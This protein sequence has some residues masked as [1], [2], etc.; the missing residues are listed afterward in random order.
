[1]AGV[2][3]HEFIDTALAMRQGA[4]REGFGGPNTVLVAVATNAVLSRTEA[5]RLATMAAAGMGRVVS[6]AHTTFD[7]D[8][9]FALS[10]GSARADVNA[11]GAA[12]AEATARAIV[13]GVTQARSVGGLRGLAGDRK[14]TRLNSSH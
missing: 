9:L 10:A 12:A 14:S 7:G 5:Q 3:S 13:R 11:L 4:V 2:D 6:P 1:R 8:I